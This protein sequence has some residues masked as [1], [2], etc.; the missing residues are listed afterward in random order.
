MAALQ[1]ICKS[2]EGTSNSELDA[3]LADNSEWITLWQVRQLLA[4]GFI[5]YRVDLFGGPARYAATDLG[6]S[7]L[8][9]MTGQ[10]QPAATPAPQTAA[11]AALPAKPISPPAQPQQAPPAKA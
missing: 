9:G 10:G 5:E 3:L 7:A 1:G 4:L 6:R 2:K 8:S 11:A